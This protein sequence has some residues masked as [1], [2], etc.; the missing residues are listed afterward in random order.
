MSELEAKL[1]TPAPDTYTAPNDPEHMPDGT[2]FIVRHASGVNGNKGFEIQATVANSAIL[3]KRF[4]V[5]NGGLSER[6]RDRHGFGKTKGEM[7]VNRMIELVR[8]MAKTRLLSDRITG[9]NKI[10]FTN[11][12]QAEVVP[13]PK[14]EID[15]RVERMILVLSLSR[16]STI[17]PSDLERMCTEVIESHRSDEKFVLNF[18]LAAEPTSLGV[19]TMLRGLLSYL[20]AVPIGGMYYT[21]PANGRLTHDLANLLRPDKQLSNTPLRSPNEGALAGIDVS[22]RTGWDGRW[23][24]SL[25]FVYSPH[26]FP[27]H[28]LVGK[29]LAYDHRSLTAMEWS[30][31][32]TMGLDDVLQDDEALAITRQI[33]AGEHNIAPATSFPWGG[34][35]AIAP[36]QFPL[37]NPLSGISPSP[38]PLAKI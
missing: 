19:A 34:A 4:A 10:I 18:E 30:A 38:F 9:K 28:I 15:D 35:A 14:S 3:L 6:D 37:A 33:F 8:T 20:S 25:S 5:A 29:P 31:L 27:D 12:V 23:V 17:S 24:L 26:I 22:V 32:T 36:V 7:T 16:G 13:C 1:R 2:H 11:G 21:D